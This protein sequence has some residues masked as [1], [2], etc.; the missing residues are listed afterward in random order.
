MPRMK[1]V[2]LFDLV[3]VEDVTAPHAELSLLGAALL[4]PREDAEKILSLT[5]RADYYD[6]K[7]QILYDALETVLKDPEGVPQPPAVATA[8]GSKLQEI[9]GY[10]YLA[11][12][13][14]EDWPGSASSIPY[15]SRL[16]RD[17]AARRRYAQQAL[18]LLGTSGLDIR[19]MREAMEKAVK[20]A[21]RELPVE[22]IGAVVAGHVQAIREKKDRGERF[23]G[24]GTPWP[25][26]DYL[27]GG[28]RAGDVT[29]LAAQSSVGKSAVGLTMA[30][31][32]ARTGACVQVASLEMGNDQ[33]S[34]RILAMIAGIEASRLRSGVLGAG[35]IE[36]LEGHANLLRTLPLDFVQKPGVKPRELYGLA[37]SLPRGNGLLMIDYLQLVT[38]DER[39]KSR[40]REVAAISRAL[41]IL[42]MDL[43][44]HV[45]ALS[46]LSRAP[47]SGNK[48]PEPT[49]RD[50]RESG[51]I[52]NDADNVMMLWRKD[53]Q[54]EKTQLSEMTL[55]LRKQRNGPTGRVEL[56]FN[57]ALQQ[58]LQVEKEPK[59]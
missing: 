53:W 50:L 49:L 27:T 13:L 9:G 35:E 12:V 20:S 6:P 34:D 4:G 14:C 10:P 39:D 11:K 5:A 7:H 42:A 15:Y 8:L 2:G 26:L 19:E 44:V 59:P 29:I 58:I 38:P 22:A 1:S 3:A 56:R 21:D 37:K 43:R 16:V 52:E 40:E 30:I 36:A 18:M 54:E 41:K 17:A 33:L 23:Q 28:L 46:Q 25:L 47:K 32:A 48:N 55:F 57:R 51:A 31:H 24:I 45:L